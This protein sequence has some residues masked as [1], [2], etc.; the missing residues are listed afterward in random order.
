MYYPPLT[1]WGIGI[2]ARRLGKKEDGSEMEMGMTEA[3]MYA[4]AD[5]AARKIDSA[6]G[7]RAGFA[8]PVSSQTKRQMIVEEFKSLCSPT[9]ET[10][11]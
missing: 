6:V 10:R 5:R 9:P 11:T 8:Y 4:A 7:W 3:E 1:G 2:A